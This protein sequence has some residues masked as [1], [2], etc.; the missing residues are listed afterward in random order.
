MGPA[1]DAG[2]EPVDGPP[3]PP[4]VREREA[5]RRRR[6]RLLLGSG[7]AILLLAVSV[8]VVFA[9]LGQDEEPETASPRSSEEP[10]DDETDGAPPAEEGEDDAAEGDEPEGDEG[11]D[12]PRDR[13]DPGDPIELDDR[14]RPD[15]DVPDDE[16]IAAPDLSRLDLGETRIAE[17]FLDI[18]A[19]ER[20]MLGFQLDVRELFTGGVDPEAPDEL[21]SELS[22]VAARGADAL[23]VLRERLEE[24]QEDPRADEVR[25]AYLVHLESWIRYMVAVAEDPQILLGDTSRYTVDI[26]RTADLFVRATEELLETADLDRELRRYAEAI[27]Q[28]GFPDAED[29]QA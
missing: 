28:R 4:S 29:S 20:V 1:A 10:S 27:I 18:D 16:T 25:E 9:G 3:P 11:P 15:R 5:K 22:S 19:S 7:A 14:G 17:L 8:G 26:N 23:E 24:P 12:T 21:F 6:R 2:A 13:A